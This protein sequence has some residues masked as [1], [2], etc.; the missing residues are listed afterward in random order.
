M[1]SF[2]SAKKRNQWTGSAVAGARA[3]MMIGC[4]ASLSFSSATCIF[5]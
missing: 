5:C 1:H 3:D 2:M 4:G